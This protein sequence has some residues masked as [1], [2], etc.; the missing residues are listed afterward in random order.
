MVRCQKGWLFD[1]YPGPGDVRTTTKKATISGDVHDPARRSGRLRF[2]GGGPDR[3]R[4]RGSWPRL[5]E[6]LRQGL[7]THTGCRDRPP[8]RHNAPARGPYEL[9]SS[10]PRGHHRLTSDAFPKELSTPEMTDATAAEAPTKNEPTDEL[11]QRDRRAHQARRDPL[12]RRLRGGVR[13]VLPGARRRRHLPAPLRRQAAQLLP[14]L[15]GPERRGAGRGPDLH[16]HRGR[17]RRRPDQQLAGARRDEGDARRALRRLHE[18]PHHVRG[19]VLDGAARLR[20][21]AD[22][23]PADRLPLRRRLDADHDPD[24]QPRPRRARRRRRVRPL[25]PLGRRPARGRR[26]GLAVADATR[27]RSTSATSPRP[28][29]SGPTAPAT[30]ATPCSARSAW[31]CGSPRPW[32]ATRAGW[33]STC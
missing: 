26:R 23:R 25:R 28:A 30:A 22:R 31:R 3:R 8:V 12:V 32:P 9:V 17:G 13:A 4:A 19:P 14:R 2:P 29:R 1:Y 7:S 33:R 20:Q 5:R 21:V 27:R 15:V 11:G 24:G 16:L 18:R 10:T 6:D